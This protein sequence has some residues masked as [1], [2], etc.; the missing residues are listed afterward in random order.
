M[1]D[2]ETAIMI[3]YDNTIE[4]HQIIGDD[5]RKGRLGEG[6]CHGLAVYKNRRQLLFMSFMDSKKRDDFDHGT[7]IPWPFTLT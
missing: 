4:Y 5:D 3:S 2:H 6:F 7:Y 1:T